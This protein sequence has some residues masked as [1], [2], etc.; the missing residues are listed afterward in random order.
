MHNIKKKIMRKLVL[1]SAVFFGLVFYS[2]SSDDDN[3]SE[4][5]VELAG[6]WQLTNVDFTYMSP[7]GGRIRA[8]DACIMELVAGYRFFSDNSFFFILKPGG[9]FPTEGN[10]WTWKGDIEDFNIL[11]PNPMNPPYDFSVAPIDLT[12]AT[13]DGKTTITFN[14]KMGNKSEAKFTLV[15]TKEIDQSK[16]PVLTQPDGS[17]FYCGFF[18]PK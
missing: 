1:L 5:K 8:T 15:K 14:S 12:M 3:S 16:L 7:D 9:P 10:Y 17:S 2:C 4:E 13:V 6:D 11:Q 18:D